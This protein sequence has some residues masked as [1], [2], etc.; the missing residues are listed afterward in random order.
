MRISW[1]PRYGEDAASSRIRVFAVHRALEGLAESVLHHDPAADV[2][3]VQKAVD[4]RVFDLAGSFRG[5]VVYDFDDVMDPAVMARA[6]EVADLFTTDTPGR[7]AGI[8][9]RCEIVPDCIDYGPEAPWP[10]SEGEGAVWFGN[11]PNF[12]SARWMAKALLEAGVPVAA[13]SD[14]SPDRA[15]LPMRLSP[16]SYGTFVA[17]IRKAA[18]A[19]LSHEGSDP[20]KSNNKMTAAV[21]F[22][23]PCIVN[24]SSAYAELAKECGLSY[25]VVSEPGDLLDAYRRL[26]DP[27][28]R[29]RYLTASQFLVWERYRPRAVARR[30]PC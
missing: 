8:T 13:V 5:R 18:V 30:R 14:L 1:I 27:A 11:Y 16:W 25:S 12:E 10:P 22:G 19:I 28:E 24:G 7:R 23:V 21:T 29:D 26:T 6:H 9:K 4:E 15:R 3:V 20:C 17:E 2:L